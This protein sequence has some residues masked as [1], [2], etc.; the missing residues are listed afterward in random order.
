M[1]FCSLLIKE[2]NLFSKKSKRKINVTFTLYCYTLIGAVAKTS[3]PF[4][5]IDFTWMYYCGY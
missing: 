3:W 5:T 4:K 2:K 1:H